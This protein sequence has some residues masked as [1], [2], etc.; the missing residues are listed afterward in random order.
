[1][2]HVLAVLEFLQRYN[3]ALIAIFTFF[4]VAVTY[5]YVRISKWL[6]EE[7]R[8]LRKAG[9]EPEL[10]AYL[11]PAKRYPS[12]INFVIANV[13]QGPARHIRVSLDADLDDF[14]KHD[15]GLH[16][17]KILEGMNI[18]PQGEKLEMLLGPRP[19]LLKEPRLKPF[20][21]RLDY[22]DLSGNSKCA[23]FELD[24]QQ[25]R[26]LTTV[27]NRPEHEMA[28]ALKKIAKHMEHWSSGFKRLKVETITHA[29]EQKQREEWL[30]EVYEELKGGEKNGDEN[31]NSSSAPS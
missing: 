2:E 8:I 22:E 28:E 12:V 30:S 1:M 3:G 19:D 6:V 9:T 14:A 13:G 23:R 25:F 17:A 16:R 5:R 20:G 21:V 11:F 26:G 4:L 29:E 10:V 27:N 7:N 18:L 31:D 24:V 15:V